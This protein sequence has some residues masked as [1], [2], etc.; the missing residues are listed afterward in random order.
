[1]QYDALG[2]RERQLI[3]ARDG[4]HDD[5]GILDTRLY[6]LCDRARDEGLD[7]DLVPSG[8]HDG[9]PEGR[10]IKLA[11]G[12]SLD[13]THHVL[14]GCGNCARELLLNILRSRKLL[15]SWKGTSLVCPTPPRSCSW[16]SRVPTATYA[17]I[18]R[19][20]KQQSQNKAAEAV[21]KAAKQFVVL[22]D[23]IEQ[24]GPPL[25]DIIKE[26]KTREDTKS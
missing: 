15:D 3:A 9:N 2:T 21:K 10:A 5:I 19:F 4:Q 24:K 17:L 25:E 11:G 18:Y 13:R 22:R 7:D 16:L 6:Q 26:W 1:M 14:V 8:V 23:D 12:R 20:L